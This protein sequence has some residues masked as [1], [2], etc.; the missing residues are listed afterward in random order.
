MPAQIFSASEHLELP[1]RPSSNGGCRPLPGSARTRPRTRT[2]P[3]RALHA[4]PGEDY[5]SFA[6]LAERSQLADALKTRQS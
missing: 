2:L 6:P 5:H 3:S 1:G 4:A